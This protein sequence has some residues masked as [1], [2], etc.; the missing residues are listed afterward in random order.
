MPKVRF[1]SSVSVMMTNAVCPY[2]LFDDC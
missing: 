1:P 2:P